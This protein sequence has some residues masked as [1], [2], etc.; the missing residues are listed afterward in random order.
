MTNVTDD[1]A[2]ALKTGIPHQTV[3]PVKLRWSVQM[4][5]NLSHRGQSPKNNKFEMQSIF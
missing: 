1:M 3:I 2:A 5:K 4:G